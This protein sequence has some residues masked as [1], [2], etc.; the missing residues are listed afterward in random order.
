[1]TTNSN[2]ELARSILA[3]IK[4][5]ETNG[6]IPKTTTQLT[7]SSPSASAYQFSNS[8]DDSLLYLE[9]TAMQL[10]ARISTGYFG[11]TTV[12]DN[13]IRNLLWIIC[14]KVSRKLDSRCLYHSGLM[15]YLASKVNSIRFLIDIREP[16]LTGLSLE[17]QQKV[18]EILEREERRCLV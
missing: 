16:L 14:P 15:S 1:M 17:Q 10:K 8:L 9:V 3:K 18:L 4:Q 2:I 13:E 6:F 5:K 12:R 11:S 7:S